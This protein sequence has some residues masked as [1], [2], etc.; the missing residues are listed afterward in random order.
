MQ[1]SVVT[2]CGLSSR[3]L[4]TIESGLSSR[5]LQT[6]ESGLSSCGA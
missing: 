3:G 4:Q 2:A 5:G 6:T 1:A